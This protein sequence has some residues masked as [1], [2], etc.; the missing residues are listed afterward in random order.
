[1]LLFRN[2]ELE[3]IEQVKVMVQARF[4]D[5]S[6]DTAE[7]ADEEDFSDY[8]NEYNYESAGEYQHETSDYNENGAENAGFEREE[9]LENI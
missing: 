3:L 1:M 9:Q 5:I 7:R 8:E 4:G 2:D 6:E